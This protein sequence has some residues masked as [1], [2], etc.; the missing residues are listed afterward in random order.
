MSVHA[1]NLSLAHDW[2]LG[3]HRHADFHEMIVVLDGRIETDVGGDR[4]GGGPGTVLLY[5]K[6][7]AHEERTAGGRPLST[8]CLS[9]TGPAP[10]AP[11]FQVPDASGRIASASR[12]IAELSGDPSVE[13]EQIRKGLMAAVLHELARPVRRPGDE[14]VAKVRAFTVPRLS[15]PIGLDDLAAAAGFSR[16]HFLRVFRAAV[17][18]TPMRW[19][20]RLRVQEARTLL[21]TTELPL[22]AIAPRVG[23]ADEFQLSR[24]FRR[25][26]GW[27]PSRVR[28]RRRS[29]P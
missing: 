20:R 23:F 9:W 26:T 13:S 4:V 22:R 16:Y 2:H 11:P 24:V 27:P 3:A 17:G 7:V 18:V 6:N 19:L 15:R 10:A 14:L 5:P 1:S 21:L 28:G 12:W 25:E 29:C 8:V